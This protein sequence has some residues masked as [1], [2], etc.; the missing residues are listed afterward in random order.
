[1]ADKLMAV[2]RDRCGPLIGRLDEDLMTQSTR[3]LMFAIGASG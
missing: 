1:M 2:R 3:L